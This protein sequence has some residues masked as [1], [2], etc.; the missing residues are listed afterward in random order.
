M[1]AVPQLMSK[2]AKD[3][4]RACE[5]LRDYGYEEVNLNI[6]CP[7]GTVVN[8]GRGAGMLANLETLNNFLE[9]VFTNTEL[10]ISIKT[11]IGMEHE[12]EW[13]EILNIYNQYSFS[14]IT[15]F[16]RKIL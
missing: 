5:M 16:P 15:Q 7:S 13:R 14:I 2:N 8:K 10:S 6:G 12:E 1:Y 4:V 3:V 11:R 9:E